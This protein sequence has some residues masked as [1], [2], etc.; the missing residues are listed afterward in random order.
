MDPYGAGNVHVTS[1]PCGHGLGLS[2]EYLRL[3]V[4]QTFSAS[5]NPSPPTWMKRGFKATI[6]QQLGHILAT[7]G[8]RPRTWLKGSTTARTFGLVSHI[9]RCNLIILHWLQYEVQCR[10]IQLA[11]GR[12]A[13]QPSATYEQLCETHA[14]AKL[15][16]S[17][18]AGQV[19]ATVLPDPSA[20]V[21][22][23]QHTESY[24]SHTAYLIGAQ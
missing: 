9:L 15:S 11:A 20:W 14:R 24:L 4:I 10:G 7:L 2:Q 12:P 21:L 18:N 5:C 19:F 23:R 17:L 3:P 6:H 13:K 16:Y 1:V 22:F 8:R